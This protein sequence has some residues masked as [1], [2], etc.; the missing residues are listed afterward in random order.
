MAKSTKSENENINE[1]LERVRKGDSQAFS[2]LVELYDPML[3][4]TLSL[5]KSDHMSREDVEDLAQEGLIAFYRAAL[6]FNEQQD[7][8]KFGLYAKTCVTNSMISYKRAASKKSN[9]ISYV[10][11]EALEK[12]S[13]PDGEPSRQFAQKESERIIGEQIERMLSPYENEVWGFYVNGHSTTE[14][15]SLLNS[16][17]KS[18]DNAIFRIRKKIKTQLRF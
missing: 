8:V 13:D 1:L 16:S 10:G 18:I 11:D 14:I 12:L 3:K 2:Y 5:Y 9:E 15:A 4:N 7:K 6:T 17:E